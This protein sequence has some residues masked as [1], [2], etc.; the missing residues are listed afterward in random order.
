VSEVDPASLGGLLRGEVT[1]LARMLGGASRET[2]SFDLD[3]VPLVLRRDP[4]GAPR[5]GAMTREGALLRAAAAAGVPVP[6]VVA[7]SDDPEPLG[8]PYL[9]MSRLDGETIARRIL[10]D[11]QYAAARERLTAQLAE[12]A[13]LLHRGLDVRAVAG[14]PEDAD[15]LGALRDVLDRF[16][17]PH[18][19]LELGFL[20]LAAS[21]PV[22]AGSTVVHGDFRLGNVMVDRDGLVGVLDWE[23]AHVGDPAE[24]LG[25]LCV[26]S[27]RFGSAL[28]V[29]GVGTRDALLSSYAAAGGFPV[30]AEMLGWWEAFG[31]LRWAVICVQQAA[32]HLSGAVRSVEL[33][34]I[35][36][37]VC[38][39][40]LDLLDLLVDPGE[41]RP[42]PQAA[43]ETGPHDRPTAGELVEAV[44]EWIG[45][46]QLAGRDAFLARVATRAL[47]VVGR[48][49]E[50]GPALAAVH[51]ERLAALGVGSD[52]EL[53]ARIR[54][55]DDR[56]EVARA[57]REAVVD[58][59]RVA[60]PRQ[61]KDRY[62]R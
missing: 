50:L 36:R 51:R 5:G 26:R 49:L 7:A 38:E 11:E 62:A 6:N 59:L 44:G 35:G 33:A 15:P 61:L 14:L 48:E 25:W 4:P 34:A 1:G 2:W 8:S 58:K 12:A 55:G 53:A 20:R 24:D 45:G 37:R 19:A 57:V 60:D 31:T 27:W 29:A 13:A 42:D 54:A 9:V 28:P 22:P 40:E 3:G 16:G 39:V 43:P 47:D 52:A 41:I 23:L 30:D 18:P 56:P 21:R 17:E 46:L 10:R 32:T